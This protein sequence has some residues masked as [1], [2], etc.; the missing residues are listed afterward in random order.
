M[1]CFLGNVVDIQEPDPS[2]Q[3]K[4]TNPHLSTVGKS[5]QDTSKRGQRRDTA[6][7]MNTSDQETIDKLDNVSEMS[8]IT[9]YQGK[10]EMSYFKARENLS[11]Q[12]W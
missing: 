4:D 1:P 3:H 11:S 2:V 7:P 12:P 5:D 6:A 10:K 9:F 8:E